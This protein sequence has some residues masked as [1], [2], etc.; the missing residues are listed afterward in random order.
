MKPLPKDSLVAKQ[1]PEHRVADPQRPYLSIVRIYASC[2]VVAVRIT[3]DRGRTN[4]ISISIKVALPN[5]MECE[6]G[7][8]FLRSFRMRHDPCRRRR[9]RSQKLA[10]RLQVLTPRLPKLSRRLSRRAAWTFGAKGPIAAQEFRKVSRLRSQLPKAEGTAAKRDI[11]APEAGSSPNHPLIV[12]SG[13]TRTKVLPKFS[14]R[15]ISA[16]AVGIT[17]NPSRISSR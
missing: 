11:I 14:P 15:S 7:Q 16:K 5:L 8:Q 3:V 13:A 17:S 4:H 10:D 6:R 12:G 2:R 1:Y 9:A